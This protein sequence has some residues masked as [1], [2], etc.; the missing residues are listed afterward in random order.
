MKSVT[1]FVC[2]M[3]MTRRDIMTVTSILERRFVIQV[4]PYRIMTCFFKKIVVANSHLIFCQLEWLILSLISSTLGT[5]KM[6]MPLVVL[7]YTCSIYLLFVITGWTGVNCEENINECA[8]SPCL[9]C[10]GKCVDQINSYRCACRPGFIGK[11]N[12]CV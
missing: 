11:H 7:C 6:N 10:Q 2:H 3:T 4:G 1:S 12:L 8:S 9:P 5:A